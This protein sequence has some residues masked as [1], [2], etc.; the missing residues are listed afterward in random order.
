MGDGKVTLCIKG[1]HTVAKGHMTKGLYKLDTRAQLYPKTRVHT[2]QERLKA[3]WMTWHRRYGHIACSGLKRLC[4]ENL[5]DG[6]EVNQDSPIVD[7]EACIQAKQVCK[8]FPDSIDER[9]KDPGDLT[10]SDL[11]GPARVESIGRAKYYI[12]F[13]DDCSRR[14]S[15]VFLKHKNEAT[16]KM[17]QHLTY[18]KRRWENRPKKGSCR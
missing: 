7:C 6:L 11:W 1:G 12:S 13:I 17:K 14:V 4:Q 15:V 3:D 2:V 18:L 9:S 16:T 10:H 8:P 5:V